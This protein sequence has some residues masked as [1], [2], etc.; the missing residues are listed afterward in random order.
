MGGGVWYYR[1]G[2]R[3]TMAKESLQKV[4][5]TLHREP[6][7]W[8]EGGGLEFKRASDKLPESMWET[9]SA[10]ANT[11]GGIIVL[12]V[13]DN[14][15]V[16]GVK[17]PGVML[18]NLTTCLNNPEKVNV[19]L[20]L[21]DGSVC[22]M[23]LEG[24]E[25]I[26]I[27]VPAADVNQKPIYCG[28]NMK[29]TFVRSNESDVRC[30]ED[31][32][33]QMIRDK[34]LKSATARLVHHTAWECVDMVSWRAYRN[35]MMSYDPS[36]AWVALEDKALLEKLGGYVRSED[37]KEDGLTLAG[38]LMFG[39]D[40]AIRQ[41]FPRF[42][43]DY[44]EY[45]GSE[46]RESGKRWIERIYNDGSWNC[47][48]F[49]FFFRVLPRLTEPLKRPFRLNDDMTAL[50]ETAAHRAI[51]EAFANAVVHADYEGDGGIIIRRYPDR[52]VFINPGTLLISRERMMSGGVSVCRNPEL[53][54]MFLRMGIVEKAGAGVDTILKGW[55]EQS[56]M[57]PQIVERRDPFQI[58]W[59]LPFISI[60]PKKEE[61]ELVKHIGKNIYEGLSLEQRTLL[62]IISHM[63]KA[64]NKEIRE[65][66]PYIHTYDLTKRLAELEHLGCLRSEGKTSAKTYRLSKI[67]QAEGMDAAGRQ[68][69]ESVI[70]VRN[71]KRVPLDK[72]KQAILD[73]CLDRWTSSSEMGRLLNRKLR[74]LH[75]ALKVLEATKQLELLHPDEPNHPQ[76]AYRAAVR[77]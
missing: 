75:T 21:A 77:V 64:G 43:V 27:S 34:M 13:E 35:R 65:I 73:I 14:G 23:N 76:Q 58:E 38:L 44:F 51:R 36:H 40:D 68:Y 16:S 31:M 5:V 56:F 22:A 45:D 39:T 26:A 24:Y 57:P 29:N 70:E 20:C 72:L 55:M 52:V 66:Y 11:D 1:E 15:S 74:S 46:E 2:M 63:K 12:G 32:I 71:S 41:F 4:V 37:G 6:S 3:E 25:I 48:L 62:L 7:T 59:M 61:E 53:Q 42:H 28:G 33:Q 60:I 19:N 47:N 8:I 50:G 10:F 67:V 49:Q 69:P 54:T 9:Y 30:R 17:N 18:K